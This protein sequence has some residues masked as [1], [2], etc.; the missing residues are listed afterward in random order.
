METEEVR[1]PEKAATDTGAEQQAE[2][3]PAAEAPQPA[4][5]APKPPAQDWEAHYKNLQRTVSLKD[6]EL[7]EARAQ[8]QR[9]AAMEVQLQQT[10]E[11]LAEG[12]D[13]IMTATGAVQTPEPQ[14]PAYKPFRQRIQEQR[15]EAA[16]PKPQP[17]VDPEQQ[18]LNEI[19]AMIEKGVITKEEVNALD[20]SVFPRPSVGLA[21]LREVAEERR[22]AHR[23]EEALTKARKSENQKR[24]QEDPDLDLDT[25]KGSATSTDPF[26]AIE[27]RFNSGEASFEEYSAARK[28]KG[29]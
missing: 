3:Q 1:Q 20:V 27:R 8:A 5:A 18:A 17:K 2:A 15:A 16:A 13:T 23:V 4:A 29:L 28:K 19:G 24:L 12:L 6:R 9:V 22:I 11:L 21:H 14:A 7:T 25:G 10:Q 26:D